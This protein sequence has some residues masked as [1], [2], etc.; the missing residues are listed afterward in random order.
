ME[1]QHNDSG[2]CNECLYLN[3]GRKVKITRAI[4]EHGKVKFHSFMASVS[5]IQFNSPYSDENEL[6]VAFAKAM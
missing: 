6:M 1:C 3:K 2:K 5:K 4:S